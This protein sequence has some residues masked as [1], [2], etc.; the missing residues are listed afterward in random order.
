MKQNTE[1]IE[2]VNKHTSSKVGRRKIE[3][4]KMVKALIPIDRICEFK[5]VVKAFQK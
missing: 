1:V 2:E 3:N 5:E 4:A